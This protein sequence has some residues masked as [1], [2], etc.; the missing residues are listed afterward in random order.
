[1]RR[2]G[3]S[4]AVFNFLR[5]ID[6]LQ[7]LVMAALLGVGLIFIR[8]T[9]LQI[10]TEASRGFFHRQLWWI[11]V[12]AGGYI[13]FSL[14]DYRSFFCRSAMIMGYLLALILLVAVL[15]FGLKVFG[16][17]R[18]L[19]IFG[20]RL[21]PSEP[22][23]LMVIGMMAEVFS[24]PRLKNNKLLCIFLAGLTVALPFFLIVIE[25][26]LGSAL[27]LLPVAGAMLF[28]FGIKW[29]YVALGLAAIAAGISFILLDSFREDPLL[30][31]NYQRDRIK[32]F[33][34]PG[35]D[36]GNRGHNAFQAKLAVGSGG[37]SG[38]GIGKGTQ[39]E[40]GF[41]PHTV[42]NND[43]IFSVIAE[44]TGFLGSSALLLLYGLLLYSILRTAFMVSGYGRYLAS[45]ICT[46]IFCHVFINI[47]MSAG[48][49]PV[50]GLP[51]PLVSYG[52]SFILTAMIT[53]GIMQSVYRHARLD[54]MDF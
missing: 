1:M 50:T 39:N 15:F 53:L 25:P 9:G 40:L 14:L 47:G 8:S 27:V 45:G 21:Q 4:Q 2:T 17:T 44:E 10:D 3:R 12:G 7:L 13:L 18:W 38:T 20:F 41:L 52:G 24:A 43:F 31:R 34:N 35:S 33:L 22:A 37:L 23:K 16:A 54:E 42:S 48:I 26:D 11:V 51:L 36:R 30:L 28:C 6:Y 46:L 49:A 29:R 19:N 32:I 5:S